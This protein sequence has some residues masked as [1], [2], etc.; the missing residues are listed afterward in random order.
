MPRLPR[1]LTSISFSFLFS[2][3]S[4]LI[5]DLQPHVDFGLKLVGADAMAIPGLYRFAQVASL[6]F[7]KG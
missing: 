3:L 7:C 6:T 1:L 2:L 4:Y 5:N